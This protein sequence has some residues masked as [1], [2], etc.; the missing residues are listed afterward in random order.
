[1]NSER[2][3]AVLFVE[4]EVEIVKTG[5]EIGEESLFDGSAPSA[6][7]KLD[8]RRWSAITL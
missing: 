4:V 5:L 6:S 2:L 1:M 7:R 8:V 3:L